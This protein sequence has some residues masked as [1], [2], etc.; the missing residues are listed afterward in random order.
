MQRL[1]DLISPAEGPARPLCKKAMLHGPWRAR[2]R[3]SW[4]QGVARVPPGDVVGEMCFLTA[5]T[6][7][8]DYAFGMLSDDNV[9]AFIKSCRAVYDDLEDGVKER[10]LALKRSGDFTKRLVE[11]Y[12]PRPTADPARCGPPFLPRKNDREL[13]EW[14]GVYRKVGIRPLRERTVQVSEIARAFQKGDFVRFDARSLL[15]A[16]MFNISLKQ[17]KELH[18]SSA[19]EIPLGAGLYYGQLLRCEGVLR[20]LYNIIQDFDHELLDRAIRAVIPW[21]LENNCDPFLTLGEVGTWDLT[22]EMIPFSPFYDT[23]LVPNETTMAKFRAHRGANQSLSSTCLNL[24]RVPNLAKDLHME[25]KLGIQDLVETTHSWMWMG[26]TPGEFHSDKFDNVLIQLTGEVDVLV[27]PSN[28]SALLDDLSLHVPF[29]NY[30]MSGGPRGVGK[31]PFFHI[32]LRSGEGIAIPSDANHKV[33]N[34]DSNRIGLNTFFEPKFKRMEWP[35]NPSNELLRDNDDHKAVRLLWVKALRHLYDT[36]KIVMYM[37][38][39]R[40]ELM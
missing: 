32:T 29:M 37:H 40:L 39:P 31:A 16:H 11:D 28:C 25:R 36:R 14:A 35:G 19:D 17:M 27:Y 2:A 3:R 5:F 18:E 6:K 15:P 7:E 33:I 24:R 1:C 10:L 4:E 20:G 26:V 9:E 34:R 12:A 38:T 30:T 13:G 23:R 8:C 21:V 22:R